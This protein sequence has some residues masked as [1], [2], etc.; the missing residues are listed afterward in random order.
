[1]LDVQ[2]VAVVD[3]KPPL[4]VIVTVP[5]GSVSGPVASEYKHPSSETT[6]HNVLHPPGNASH[7]FSHPHDSNTVIGGL[8]HVQPAV[9]VLTV[10]QSMVMQVGQM[11]VVEMMMGHSETRPV[12]WSVGSGFVVVVTVTGGGKRGLVSGVVMMMLVMAVEVGGR[13]WDWACVASA[14]ETA[15]RL[16]KDLIFS[17]DVF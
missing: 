4:E 17:G 7:P 8:A 1:M 12:G 15:R 14:R 3:S 10:T 5:V 6:F 2:F 9:T 13:D 11:L 16:V